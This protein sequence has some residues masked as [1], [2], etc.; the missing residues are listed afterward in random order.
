MSKN[1]KDCE[2][3]D[4]KN[5]CCYLSRG[6][7]CNHLV[8]EKW[9]PSKRLLSISGLKYD[10]ALEVIKFYADK[11][12]WYSSDGNYRDTIDQIDIDGDFEAG[13]KARAFLKKLEELYD[14]DT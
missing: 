7:L 14:S 4:I 9:C 11:N 12:N 1:C 5:D 3:W 6:G 13:K 2:N 8:K 10:D